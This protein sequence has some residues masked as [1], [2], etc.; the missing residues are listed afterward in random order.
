MGTSPSPPRSGSGPRSWTRRAWLGSAGGAALALVVVGCRR[1]DR[2]GR[3][4][5]AAAMSLAEVM[6]RIEAMAERGSPSVDVVLNL[7]GSQALA[8]QLL[9]GARADVFVSA[10]AAQLQR[11][12]DAGLAWPPQVIASNRLVAIVAKGSGLALPEELGRA[13]VKVVL[14]APEVPAGA[15][16][17]EALGRMGLREQVL[18]NLVSDEENVGAVVQRVS[19]GEADAGIVYATDVRAAPPG[20]VAVIE[21]AEAEPVRANYLASP[22]RASERPEEAAGF[23]E[24]LLA[25]PAQ[26]IFAELGFGPP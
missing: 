11:V 5:V 21:L 15:Y 19:L 26:A 4:V 8:A 16:A 13:G 7:A 20:S 10:N 2:S 23:I 1:R 17:R 22:L 9:G 18:G 3:L 6:A 24:M 12:V 14:A 25:P